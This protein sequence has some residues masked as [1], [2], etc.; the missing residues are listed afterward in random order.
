M[1][2]AASYDRLHRVLD[3]GSSSAASEVSGAWTFSSAKRSFSVSETSEADSFV[4]AVSDGVGRLSV[5]SSQE[6]LV[7]QSRFERVIGVGNL[8][9]IRLFFMIIY[10]HLL[11]VVCWY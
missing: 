5:Y 1:I 8:I 10:M 11:L 3:A 2:S 6:T 7:L 9:S 4:S